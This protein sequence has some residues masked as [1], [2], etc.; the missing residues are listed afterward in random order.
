MRTPWLSPGARLLLAILCGAAVGAWSPL[1]LTWLS[2]AGQAYIALL[3]MVGLPL[4]VL[5]VWSGLRQWPS[6]PGSMRRLLALLL[7]GLLAMMA[8]A[9]L[10]AGLAMLVVTEP[11]GGADMATAL[12]RAALEVEAIPT[13]ALRAEPAE[14]SDAFAALT[15]D[16]VVPDNGYRAL[17]YGTLV[18]AL[19][20]VVFFGVGLAVQGGERGRAFLALAEGVYRSLETLMARAHAWLPLFAFAMAAASVHTLGLALLG[21]MQAFLIPLVLIALAVTA[22]ALG[23]TALRLRQP[24]D[25]VVGAL[26]EPLVIGLFSTGPAAAV[27]GLIDAMCNRLGGRR[28][29]MELSAPLLPA[30]VRLGDA[31]FFGVLAVFA[32]HLYGKPLGVTDLGVIELASTA[33]ALA[34]VAY[35][36]GWTLAAAGLALGWLG[37]PL[38]ALLPTLVLLEPLTAGIRNLVSI[39]VVAPWVTLAAGPLLTGV[40]RVVEPARR[41]V[42]PRVALSLRPRD[43]LLLM[44]LVLFALLAAG[45]AGLGVGLLDTQHTLSLKARIP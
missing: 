36:S 5:A 40:P 11:G 6:Q 34:S 28:D 10:A 24:V 7:A 39:V 43:A 31:L 26:R 20:G 23:V 30:F 25:R 9:G 42:R 19:I 16:T 15:W 21:R 3:N 12:G 45:L 35:A 2:A 27:P 22:L 32:A 8:L 4:I 17:A 41:V 44:G 29:L 33:A 13:V 14:S 1:K 37:L 18:S 38:E